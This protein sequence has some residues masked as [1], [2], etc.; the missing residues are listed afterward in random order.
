M[1]KSEKIAGLY[2]I[3]SVILW[4]FLELSKDMFF[5]WIG[6]G[7]IASASGKDMSGFWGLI[8]EYGAPFILMGI[9]LYFLFYRTDKPEPNWTLREAFKYLMLDSK[10]SIGRKVNPFSSG[11]GPA[12]PYND[13]KATINKAIME[14]KIKF[15]Y[16]HNTEFGPKDVDDFDIDLTNCMGS[17]DSAV[18]RLFSEGDWTRFDDVMVNKRQFISVWPKANWYQK[19]KDKDLYILRYLFYQ[20]EYQHDNG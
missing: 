7:I 3:L 5:G 9:G 15:W 19:Y 8:F 17:G 4:F 14:S 1:W 18:L 12:D 20:K 13:M 11:S 2:F 10:W 16:Q 6:D